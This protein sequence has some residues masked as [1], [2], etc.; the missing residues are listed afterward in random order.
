MS[1]DRSAVPVVTTSRRART[2][3]PV[4]APRPPVTA[5]GGRDLVDTL[6]GDHRTV[7]NLFVRLERVGR[8]PQRRR[9]LVD[10]II[11]ELIRHLVAEQRYLYPAVRAYLDD[12][13]EVIVRALSARH[14][15]ERL[16]SDLMDTDVEHP[17]F[18]TLVRR[19][20][21]QVRARVREEES[22]IF[23]RLRAACEPDV[24][25]RIADQ[26]SG[27]RSLAPTRPHP[28]VR[29]NRL[30]GPIVGL[31]D[32]AIDALTDRPTSVQEL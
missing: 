22:T 10:V 13:D 16:M 7:E 2:R 29:L 27:A 15:T 26:V 5:H 12:G 9:D 3:A 6:V 18:D 1:A 28:A 30:T 17:R 25:F 32:Q 19:L 23:T 24:L 20:I 21:G 14:R 8:W 11:A 31:F 4:T